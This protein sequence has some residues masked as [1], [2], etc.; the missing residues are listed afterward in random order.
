[1]ETPIIV[2]PKEDQNFWNF[3]FSIFFI[4]VLAGALWLMQYVRGGYLTSVPPF[5]FL[6]MA[7]AAFRITRLIVYDKIA[8]WFR[9]LFVMRREVER[10]GKTYVEIHPYPRGFRHTIYDLLQCPWCIGIWA[11][12]IVIVCYFIFVWAWSVILFLA[13]AGVGT[14]LQLWANQLGWKAELL[15]LEAQEKEKAGFTSDHS[16]L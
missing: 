16:G 15:K 12:L 4:I 3:V 5:D 6:I 7:L 11:G 14:L 9:E 2:R 1:M 8:R 13:I 10:N